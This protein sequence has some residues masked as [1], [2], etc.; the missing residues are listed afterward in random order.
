MSNQPNPN[1]INWNHWIV[2]FAAFIVLAAWQTDHFMATGRLDVETLKAL[3]WG[4]VGRLALAW[5]TKHH[6]E[7]APPP[8]RTVP[9]AETV[10]PA[11]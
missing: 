1:D 3:F 6:K 8:P 10:G 7:E 4:M 5:D 11:I 2:G 9:P